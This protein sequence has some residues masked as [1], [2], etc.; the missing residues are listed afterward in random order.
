MWLGS[1]TGASLVPIDVPYNRSLL[2]TTH[3]PIDVTVAP[4]E[5]EAALLAINDVADAC[6]VGL[7]DERTG[8]APR[9]YVVRQQG[10]SLTEED[11]LSALRPK[12]ASYKL[13]REIVFVE[14]IPKS[15]SG[16]ILRRN[17]REAALS[18]AV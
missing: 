5:V 6:V 17:L 7:P 10:V 1:E 3:P 4:A 9:A 18:G 16:K 15:P 12:L 14:S 11:V 13:P 2:Q 8:E